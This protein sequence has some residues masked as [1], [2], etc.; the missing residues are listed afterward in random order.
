MTPGDR[1]AERPVVSSLASCPRYACVLLLASFAL[2]EATAR[3]L[4]ETTPSGLLRTRFREVAL[5]PFR[6]S[7]AVVR[8]ALD[9][10]SRDRFLETDSD[11][12]WNLRRNQ[13]EARTTPTH[14]RARLPLPGPASR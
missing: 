5:L 1:G 9:A 2:A 8:R 7:E 10:F 12:G 14:C 6:P 13:S 3:L 4:T 11:L